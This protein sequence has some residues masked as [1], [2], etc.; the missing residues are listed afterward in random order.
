MYLVGKIVSTHGIKGEVKVRAD[1]SFDRF[2]PGNTLLY[3][4]RW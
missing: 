2:I 4:K 1:T 3:K